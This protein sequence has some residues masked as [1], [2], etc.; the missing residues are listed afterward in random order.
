MKYGIVFIILLLFG[1][2]SH[3][4]K[5]ILAPDAL[6]SI[7]KTSQVGNPIYIRIFK[8]EKILELWIKAKER[9]TLY[10]RYPILKTSGLL[11][12]KREEG[13]KQN[14]EGFYVIDYGR[15]NPN[16]RYHL[17]LNIGYPNRRERN[18]GYTGSNIMIH[19]EMKSIGCFAM[20]NPAI[21]EIY[22][23]AKYAIEGGQAYIHV[24]IF[25]FIMNNANLSL[26]HDTP[27]YPF[28]R[29][30]KEGYDF[31]E[32]EKVPAEVTVIK[33]RYL[34]KPAL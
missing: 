27:W 31:F 25:P 5:K 4:E 19:G 11:G 8:N 20:G 1:A 17:A 21:E 30:L 18:I 22:A 26:Y 3:K 34:F 28:W 33:G 12:P 6:K 10:K 23:L 16:S 9:Y 2:C 7:P 29:N 32:R 13:D 24:A 15:L 14:P